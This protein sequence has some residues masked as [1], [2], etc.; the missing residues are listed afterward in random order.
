MNRY[1]NLCSELNKFVDVDSYATC[2]LNGVN[3]L[4]YSYGGK[5]LGD[6]E[7]NF[8]ISKDGYLS[9]Y[10]LENFSE[11]DKNKIKNILEKYSMIYSGKDKPL[12]R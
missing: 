1:N 12:Y 6:K 4:N 11:E 3:D 7:L 9:I 2:S 8:N 10:Y 5:Y